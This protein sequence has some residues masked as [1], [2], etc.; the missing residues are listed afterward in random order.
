MKSWSCRLCRSFIIH[1]I[2][3]NSILRYI[4][5]NNIILKHNIITLCNMLL[6][7]NIYI[8]EI[9]NQ[10]SKSKSKSKSKTG[11][12]VSNPYITELYIL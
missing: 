11:T 12:A 9:R 4:P 10:K 5:Y 2:I 3:N 8:I 1:I 7:N 6:K